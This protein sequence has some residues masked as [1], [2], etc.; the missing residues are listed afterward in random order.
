MNIDYIHSEPIEGRGKFRVASYGAHEHLMT[1]FIASLGDSDLS[2]EFQ[3][4]DGTNENI[5]NHLGI[6]PSFHRGYLSEDYWRELESQNLLEK[7]GESFPY[8]IDVEKRSISGPAMFMLYSH[9][10]LEQTRQMG[11]ERVTQMVVDRL[12][13]F[14]DAG[15]GTVRDVNTLPGILLH[16]DFTHPTIK[17]HLKGV[18]IAPLTLQGLGDDIKEKVFER[19]G[20]L[21]REG[22]EIFVKYFG[23]GSFGARTVNHSYESDDTEQLGIDMI[24]QM[25]FDGV[26]VHAIGDKAII[27]TTEFIRDIHSKAAGPAIDYEIHHVE[28]VTPEVLRALQS[29]N[30]DCKSWQIM[31]GDKPKLKLCPQPNFLAY[32]VF[33]YGRDY[34]IRK[35]PS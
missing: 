13:E 6:D 19:L 11:E 12:E 28:I 7:I 32:D 21:K 10:N 27:N 1:P 26:I 17:R 16:T 24:N 23:D 31:G 8:N 25:D 4:Q 18:S 30:N 22:Y 34:N 15:F 20:Y 5:G 3:Y 2:V 14:Y 29:L 9:L 35:Q 33:N